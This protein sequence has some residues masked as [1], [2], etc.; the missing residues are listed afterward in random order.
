MDTAKNT[1]YKGNPKWVKGVSGNPSG[2][3]KRHKELREILSGLMPEAGERLKK[4]LR[5]EDEKIAIEAVKLVAAYSL[6][7]PPEA[8]TVAHLDA[9]ETRREA[10]VE[11][12]KPAELPTTVVAEAI[13][14][15]VAAPPGPAEVKA[16][17][18]GLRCLY[19]G[20]QGKCE[21]WAGEGTQ[22]C[23]EH[24]AKLFAS[25]NA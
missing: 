11:A 2:R 6:G 21:A 8:G 7:K 16:E 13:V 1:N 25:L 18:Q 14:E 19:R 10:L 15:P 20:P 22:W 5:S 17:G 23:P 4:L 3:P 12:I 9:V 24:K